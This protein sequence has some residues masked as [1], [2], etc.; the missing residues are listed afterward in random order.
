MQNEESAADLLS[1]DVRCHMRTGEGD[2]ARCERVHEWA[3][4]LDSG[5][6]E[7]WRGLAASLVS[8][9][10]TMEGAANVLEVAKVAVMVKHQM[11]IF[12][13]QAANTGPNLVARP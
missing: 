4:G 1:L 10:T 2:A 8:A 7:E 3:A 12:K 5:H 13:P 9:T 6:R 11:G